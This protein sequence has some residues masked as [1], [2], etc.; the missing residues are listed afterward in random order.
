MNNNK[1]KCSLSDH[2]QNEAI[3]FC[4]KCQIYMCNKCHK[5]HQE[6]FKDHLTYKLDKDINEIFTGFCKEPKHIDELKYFCKNHNKLCCAGCITKIKDEE[7]GQ[8]SNCNI[9]LIKDIAQ[10]KKYKLKQNLIILENLSK[11]LIESINELKKMFEFL[12]AN[13][14]NLKSNIQKIFTKI[15]NC[16]N[17]RED[18][19]LLEVEN[20]C[21]ELFLKEDIIKKSLILPDKITESLEK[22]KTIEEQWNNNNNK[23]NLLVNECLNIEN[24]I[25]EIN[26]LKESLQNYN[27]KNFKLEFIPKEKDIN[28]LLQVIKNFGN[29]Y[30]NDSNDNDNNNTS[31]YYKFKECPENTNNERKYKISGEKDN[32]VTKEFG[33]G[34]TNIICDKELDKSI[35][36]HSWKIKIKKSFNSNPMIGISTNDFDINYFSVEEGK[37]IGWFY[38]CFMGKL[39]SGPPHNYKDKNLNLKFNPRE[40]TVVM[41]MKKG[42]LKFIIDGEDKG[43]AYKNIPLDKPLYPSV[44]LFFKDDSVEICDS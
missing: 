41:N 30:Y 31:N 5:H 32:I 9:Y 8:H 36:I 43:E 26:I 3:L 6:I 38:S 11:T 15:R 37:I 14:E 7:N 28:R 16:L 34:W 18:E 19:L 4:Q 39:Y 40:I 12:N 20:K 29:I 1:K 35:E 23:L 44:L 13:K 2:S 25:S 10:E 21:D 17:D 24:N 42:S 27:S 22:G 33:H